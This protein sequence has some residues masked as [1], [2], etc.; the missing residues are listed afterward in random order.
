MIENVKCLLFL[1]TFLLSQELY[2]F[3]GEVQSINSS[4]QRNCPDPVDS[5]LYVCSEGI[6]NL[7]HP[8][9]VYP[10]AID[11]TDGSEN[12]VGSRFRIYFPWEHEGLNA[13]KFR[14]TASWPALSP[15]AVFA[16][17]DYAY[18]DVIGNGALPGTVQ[19]SIWY[20]SDC[21]DADGNI[22]SED[23]IELIGRFCFAPGDTLDWPE[24]MDQ[25]IANDVCD[26]CWVSF[27][28]WNSYDD[29]PYSSDSLSP[30]HCEM[31]DHCHINP[32]D[33]ISCGIGF[34]DEQDTSYVSISNQDVPEQINLINAYPNPFNPV[35][36]ISYHLLSKGKV[37][38][39][40]YNLKGHLIESMHNLKESVGNHVVTW[41]AINEPSGLYFIKI[42]ID[43]DVQTKKILFLK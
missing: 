13:N 33:S 26:A 20:G 22:G 9:D 16:S 1:M 30:A 42:L 28:A 25:S 7:C 37:Q 10:I 5:C 23:C 17:G 2:E 41:N 12:S 15:T 18:F 29:Y 24:Y 21:Q 38:I 36:N 19:G 39:Q 11:T 31:F 8:Q 40:I 32:P 34:L 35:I 4:F 6:E 27:P 43:K 3:S 14:V